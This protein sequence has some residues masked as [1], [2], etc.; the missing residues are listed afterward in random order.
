MAN[1]EKGEVSL[2]AGDKTY[3]LRLSINALCELE[4]A[5]GKPVAEIVKMLQASDGVRISHL[6]EI[7]QAALSDHHDGLTLKEVG[8]IMSDA[9]VDRIGAV[10]GELFAATFPSGKGDSRGKPEKN[11]PKA[12]G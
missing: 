1:R 8:S 3:T 11:P 2:A 12:K 5:F 7:V 10:L 4:D 6:R 9:G